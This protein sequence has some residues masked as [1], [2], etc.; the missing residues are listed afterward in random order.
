MLCFQA[1]LPIRFLGKCVLV[2]TYLI[3]MTCSVKLNKQPHEIMFDEK[4]YGHM[5]VLGCLCYA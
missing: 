2:V 4:H 5:K 3:N 1:S